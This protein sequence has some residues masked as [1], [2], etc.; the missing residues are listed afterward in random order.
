M[1]LVFRFLQLPSRDIEI[2]VTIMVLYSW[3][4]DLADAIFLD[5]CTALG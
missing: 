3:S 4:L 2:N 5:L 1:I